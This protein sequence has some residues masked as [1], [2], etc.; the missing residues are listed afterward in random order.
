[1]K[2]IKTLGVGK[3]LALLVALVIFLFGGATVI[4]QFSIQDMLNKMA[5]LG[6]M[7]RRKSLSAGIGADP[8]SSSRPRATKRRP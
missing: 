1:M 3:L 5:T 8:P 6:E 2:G 7:E 4:G